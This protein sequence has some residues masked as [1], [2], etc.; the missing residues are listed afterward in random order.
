MKILVTGGAGFI[1][2]WL[3]DK[4]VEKDHEVVVI[5]NFL[6]GNKDIV[7]DEIKFYELD[8]YDHDML[9]EV[10]ENEKP[11]IVFHL[12]AQ[13]MLRKSMEHPLDDAKIN[14]LGTISVLEACRKNNVKRILLLFDIFIPLSKKSKNFVI[15]FV[16]I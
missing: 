5:D 8:I 10:F 11:E 4:L 9:N 14:I 2:S 6:T 12:A 7:S 3:V 16:N 1:G 13:T 15:L